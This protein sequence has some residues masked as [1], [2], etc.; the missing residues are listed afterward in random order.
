MKQF[1]E[2]YQGKT[3]GESRLYPGHGGSGTGSSVQYVRSLI[4]FLQQYITQNQVS[5]FLDIG[6]GECEWQRAI[7]WARLGCEYI[8]VELQSDVVDR[9]RQD[10]GSR[11]DMRILQGDALSMQLPES[12]LIFIKEV[13]QHWPI[14]LTNR[15]LEKAQSASK[16]CLTYNCD[17]SPSFFR[18]STYRYFISNQ[19]EVHD[20]VVDEIT[21]KLRL[22]AWDTSTGGFRP[23]NF[24][25]YGTRLHTFYWKWHF[26]ASLV[27]VERVAKEVESDAILFIYENLCCRIEEITGGIYADADIF[28]SGRSTL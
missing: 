26:P 1:E 9:V 16:D 3:W 11:E 21:T 14:R 19:L 8:G 4:S 18:Y 28:H 13:F 23:C 22:T 6:C 2:I 20:E 10:L 24:D 25:I 27:K 5:T 12:D 17:A 15:F 7:D